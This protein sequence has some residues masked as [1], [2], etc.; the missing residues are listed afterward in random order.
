MN[1]LGRWLRLPFLLMLALVLAGC[2]KGKSS[3]SAPIVVNGVSVDI[4]KLEATITNLEIR[5]RLG[6]IRD[7]FRYND[8]TTAQEQIETAV[9]TPGLTP[10]EHLAISQVVLQIRQAAAAAPA[11][12][13]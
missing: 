11:P 5:R 8:F 7:A 4:P 13:K 3:A 10:E 9:N 1:G 6:N 12:A 2:G